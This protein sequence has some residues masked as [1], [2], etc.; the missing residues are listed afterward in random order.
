MARDRP[1]WPRAWRPARRLKDVHR[2]SPWEM[3]VVKKEHAL[4]ME[5]ERWRCY[6]L[7]RYNAQRPSRKR[8]EGL[9]QAGVMPF[10]DS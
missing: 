2:S 8:H 1:V 10:R 5:V 6:A 4:A 7:A 3:V 9:I